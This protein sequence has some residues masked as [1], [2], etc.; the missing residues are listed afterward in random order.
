MPSDYESFGIVLIEALYYD[1]FIVSSNL[2]TSKEIVTD[3]YGL[4]FE[5]GDYLDLKDKLLQ[6]CKNI[7]LNGNNSK[8]YVEKNFMYSKNIFPIDEW[9]KE[10]EEE[11]DQKRK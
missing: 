11:H 3:K 4:F 9:I 6:A 5:K 2:Y 7:T 8:Q 1:C 10:S